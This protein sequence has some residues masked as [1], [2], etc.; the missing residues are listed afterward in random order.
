MIILI[1]MLNHFHIPGKYRGSAHKDC[2]IN[3]KLNQKI[4][5][6]FHNL[7]Y[8]NY[9]LIIRELGKFSLEINVIPNGL[10]SFIDSFQFLSS[11]LDSFHKWFK[12]RWF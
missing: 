10:E 1:M 9:Y 2:D 11:S 7:K 3:L 12:Q 8:Y 6:V 4:P 5:V